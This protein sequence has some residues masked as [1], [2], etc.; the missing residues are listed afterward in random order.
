VIAAIALI[1][2][3]TPTM[4][5]GMSQADLRAVVTVM[6]IDKDD[7]K[8][9]LSAITIVPQEAEPA[10]IYH[11][12]TAEGATI[13]EAY[14]NLSIRTGRIPETGHCELIIVGKEAAEKGVDAELKYLFCA[15][16]V[17]GGAALLI[18][19]GEAAE[20]LTEEAELNSDA[21]RVNHLVRYGGRGAHVVIKSLHC[22]LS[23]MA[24]ASKCSVIPITAIEEGE[25]KGVETATVIKDGKMVAELDRVAT[26]GV[27][28]LDRRTKSG[29]VT[30][31]DFEVDEQRLGNISGRLRGKR[32]RVRVHKDD[33]GGIC[34]HIRVNI[35]LRLPERHILARFYND[36]AAEARVNRLLKE[37]FEQEVKDKIS[38]AADASKEHEADILGIMKYL[39]RHNQR[40][41][42]ANPNA[43]EVVRDVKY[44]IDVN[45][46]IV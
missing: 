20:F 18:C 40:L 38:A 7:D 46:K 26:A 23:S 1:I 8:V 39:Y 21:I 37:A 10:A 9:I 25:H 4:Y 44:N 2:A 42:K 22:Y 15:G 28:Y 5:A 11:V 32:V 16:I 19:E 17:S 43:T 36:T 24:S 12:V 35:T 30:V 27:S 14:Q 33:E 41:Y 45:V 31:E 6:G 29:T 3:L 34:A 13:S